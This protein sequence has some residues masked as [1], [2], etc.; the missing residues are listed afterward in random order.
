VEGEF[1]QQEKDVFPN[2]GSVTWN[3]VS[4]PNGQLVS[5]GL[6]RSPSPFTPLAR[7][8]T[9][10]TFCCASF[11]AAGCPSCRTL[12]TVM[13]A[14]NVCISSAK[15][16]CLCPL[17]LNVPTIQE[18]RWTVGGAISEAT[19]TLSS[20]PKRTTKSYDPT[21]RRLQLEHVSLVPC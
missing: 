3:D 1:C 7:L 18:C 12:C 21:Y 9:Q 19:R 13:S 16:G 11:T 5:K 2:Q 15:M 4:A 6:P 8:S 14:L 20:L 17:S 10:L